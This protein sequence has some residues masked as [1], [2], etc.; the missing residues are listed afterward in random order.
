MKL[1]QL[2]NRSWNY[3]ALAFAVPCTMMLVLMFITSATPFGSYSMLYSDQFHQYYP[4]FCAFRQALRSGQ[5]LL[6]NWSAGM[7]MDYLGLISYYLASPLNIFSVLV[8]DGLVMEYFALL[9]PVKLGIAGWAF[10]YMLKKLF[11]KNDLSLVLFGACYGL[12]AWALGYQWNIMWLDTFA[13]T[14][15]VALGTVQLLRDRKFILYTVTLFLAIFANYYVGF[16]VCIFV[17]LLFFCYELCRFKSPLRFVLDFCRIGV[18]TVLAIGMTAIL[19]LPALAALQNTQS[20]VNS[21]PEGFA[22]NIV[23]GEAVDAARIAW[24]AFLAAR[25][26]GTET[27][28]QL[29]SAL[30]ASFKPLTQA[31]V[32]VSGQIG[33]GQSPTYIDGLPNLYCGVFP[34]AMGF[35]FLLSGKVR[36][37]DKLCCIFLL[38]F[39]MLS[40]IVRQLDYIW[41]G[42][43]FTNQ[44][45]YRFSFLFSFVL[46]YMAYR[47][48]L[49]R[50]ECK[51]WQIITAGVLSLGLFLLPEE[52]RS[53][54][55]YLCFNFAFLGLYFTALLYGHRQFLPEPAEAA[56]QAAPAVSGMEPL[57]P[58]SEPSADDEVFD[59]E[60]ALAQPPAPAPESPAE[61][62]ARILPAYPER[63]RHAAILIAICMTLELALSIAAFAAGYGI[64]DYDYPKNG[65]ATA[66]MLQVMR[67]QENG[68]SLFYR[69]E[70]THSQTLNDGPLNGY[71]GISTFT[72]SANVRVTEFMKRMGYGA[73][74][75]YNR[76]CWEEGSP[77]SNLFLNLKYMLQR[78]GTPAENAYFDV[79]HTYQNVTLM[80]NNAYLPLGF[81]VQPELEALDFTQWQ[82]FSFQNHL[83]SAAT[84]LEG[85]VWTLIAAKDV[86]VTK[87]NVTVHTENLS[88][89]TS[90]T[91]GSGGGKLIYNYAI[92]QE[93][94]MCLDLNLYQ[95]KN[96]SVW[97]NGRQ[98]YRDSYSLP[99]MLAVGNVKPG[100][101]VQ[102]IVECTSSSASQTSLSIR[103][104]VVDETLFRQGYDVLNRSTLDLTEFST[105]Y[106][107]G[108]IT[109]DR[110]GLLYTSIPQDGNWLAYVD[111]QPV[112]TTLVGDAM[113]ALHLTAGEHTVEFRYRNPAFELGWKI[114]LVCA[115][116]FGGIVLGQ[117]LYLRRKRK[118]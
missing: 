92:T 22:V 9:M 86:V 84:G 2:K 97:Y 57:I 37:R 106:L 80:E 39:F 103:G 118:K 53:D 56:S 38:T 8:P 43:H 27:F 15:L 64:F 68:E 99:Q 16:F 17:L 93:G 35:L 31:M 104:A 109:C 111:G 73:Y 102:V 71:Y 116:V 114:S 40:F 60:K 66:S 3:P 23:S 113:L 105:T 28:G 69:T 1:P 5:S 74:N 24:D 67:E 13:I 83:F 46:L 48:W 41:H 59:V 94:F 30:L 19:E 29:W 108:D 65:D 42:F 49:I 50:E 7:G 81:L 63:K 89:Y 96:F 61:R 34:V 76:Y 88:G 47:A 115:L 91:P 98:L 20:S 72:S 107:A 87:E 54:I 110:D 62:F 18:F 32:A 117:Y 79:L 58:E 75:T 55:A 33:G 51:L 112:Q 25:E 90:F 82:S 11:D 4:F 6:W 12:C 45:P 21:F 78:E 10:A 85:N 36:V 70:M 95:Q 44:I 101:Q 100:D 26:S 14:P 77:V 52:G